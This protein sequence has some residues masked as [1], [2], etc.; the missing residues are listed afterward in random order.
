MEIR[1]CVDAYRSHDVLVFSQ[2]ATLAQTSLRPVINW[3]SKWEPTVIRVLDCDTPL[4]MRHL[5]P[6]KALTTKSLNMYNLQ[7]IN[8]VAAIVTAS[9]VTVAGKNVQCWNYYILI[10]TA[11]RQRSCGRGNVFSRVSPSVSHSVHRGRG[12]MWPFPMMHWI[13]LY[14]EPPTS[15]Q[16]WDLTVKAPFT[17]LLV[18]SGGHHFRPVQTC[19]LEDPPDQCWHLVAIETCTLGAS[20]R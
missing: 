17:T 16:T 7:Y 13:T 6:F 19:S 5:H 2:T 12:P 18:I 20:L 8:P 10:F 4:I 14:M 11:R 1:Y 3:S 15:L 9:L